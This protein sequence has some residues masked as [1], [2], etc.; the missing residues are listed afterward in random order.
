MIFDL[1]LF[2]SVHR[3]QPVY[4]HYIK[5]T[6]VKCV[7]TDSCLAYSYNSINMDGTLMRKAM[8]A[9]PENYV[10]SMAPGQYWTWGTH[11]RGMRDMKGKKA[12]SQWTQCTVNQNDKGQ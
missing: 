1:L 8:H 5:F 11:M 3:V 12:P 9:D 10:S 4:S 7:I 2:V 6:G